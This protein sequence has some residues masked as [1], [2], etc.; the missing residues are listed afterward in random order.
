[1]RTIVPLT[2]LAPSAVPL[3]AASPPEC[4]YD[5]PTTGGVYDGDTSWLDH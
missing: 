4:E 5:K 1:M 3:E 2:L